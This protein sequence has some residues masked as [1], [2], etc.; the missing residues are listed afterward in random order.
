MA[1]GG[2][3]PNMLPASRAPPA[4]VKHRS[5]PVR[6]ATGDARRLAPRD[7]PPKSLNNS[8]GLRPP[9]ARSCVSMRFR[10]VPFVACGSARLLSIRFAFFSFE[11]LPGESWCKTKRRWTRILVPGQQP[12]LSS[13]RAQPCGGESLSANRATKPMREK[14]L[15]KPARKDSLAR[16]IFRAAQG[17]AFTSATSV[18][19][20]N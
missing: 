5:V 1:G 2:L 12:L 15:Y 20:S 4:S 6:G 8:V 14:T 11:M 9:L 13:N 16:T 10:A 17:V 3:L 18:A 19:S 7:A